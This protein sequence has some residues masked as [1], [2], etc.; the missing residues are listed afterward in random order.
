[1]EVPA[2]HPVS[3]Q[4]AMPQHLQPQNVQQPQQVQQGR[5]GQQQGQQG[6]LGQQ[7]QVQ[8]GQHSQQQQVQQGQQGQQQ[9]GQQ[10][11]PPMH[12][13]VSMMRQ[14]PSGMPIRK[15]QSALELV[16]W[17]NTTGDLNFWDPSGN[18][19]EQLHSMQG[20]KAGRLTPEERL[21]KILRYRQKRQERNFNRTIKYQCRPDLMRNPMQGHPSSSGPDLMHNPMPGHPSPS[22]PDLML[23]PMRGHPSSPSPDLILNP[24]LAGQPMDELFGIPDF[25]TSNGQNSS[26]QQQ[27][28][29]GVRIKRDDDGQQLDPLEDFF[30]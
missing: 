29:Q 19:A 23:N 26:T 21:Q 28:G 2:P 10:G 4:P 8:Q 5:K 24:L 9:Q 11:R 7:Q 13:A 15:S 17:R 25:R 1:M 3:M 18:L 30:M 20:R 16:S 12:P 14:Q 27:V 22:G 6:Q